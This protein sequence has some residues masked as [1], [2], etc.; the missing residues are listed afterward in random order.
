MTA[1]VKPI[2]QFIVRQTELGICKEAQPDLRDSSLVI[3]T[4]N[5]FRRIMTATVKLMLLYFARQTALGIS[6]K[7]G[8]IYRYSIWISTD[9]PIPADYDGDGKADIAVYRNGYLVYSTEHKRIYRL[10]SSEQLM[11]NLCKMLLFL[12]LLN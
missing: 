3:Q 9:L 8:R 10:Y 5:P 1:T 11:I 6:T 12:E 4:I 7:H 2:M